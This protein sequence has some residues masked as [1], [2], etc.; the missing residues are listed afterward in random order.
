MLPSEWS[1]TTSIFKADSFFFTFLA[2]A[3]R[4]LTT[5]INVFISSWN[6]GLWTALFCTPD[7]L[8]LGVSEG[9]AFR[10]PKA[11]GLVFIRI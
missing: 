7:S 6:A 9:Q 1:Q 3:T 2:M 10:F 5:L 4:V 8:P 11:N